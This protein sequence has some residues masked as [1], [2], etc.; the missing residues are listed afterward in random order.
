VST[1]SARFRSQWSGRRS[2]DSRGHRFPFPAVVLPGSNLGQVVH[3]HTHT[4]TRVYVTEHYTYVISNRRSRGGDALR[5]HGLRTK[6][7]TPPAYTPH[8]V[9]HTSLRLSNSNQEADVRRGEQMSG[10]VLAM[11]P[12]GYRGWWPSAQLRFVSSCAQQQTPT[13]AQHYTCTRLDGSATTH[14]T[15]LYYYL[16]GCAG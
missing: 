2:H 10:N 6:I 16:E 8:G 11:A 4:H 14:C 5:A 15:G 12:G 7:S 3:T 1:V 9:R 13:S